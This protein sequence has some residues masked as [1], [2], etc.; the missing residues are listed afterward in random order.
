MPQSPFTRAPHHQGG[1][2]CPQS[3]AHITAPGVPCRKP[4]AGAVGRIDSEAPYCPLPHGLLR[5]RS[6]K[7]LR[8]HLVAHVGQTEVFE[9][10]YPN[11]EV[12]Y[13]EN[14]DRQCEAFLFEG[15][16]DLAMVVGDKPSAGCE[17]VQLYES[18]FYFWMPR[19]DPLA[20]V[21]ETRPLEIA[22][23][24]GR[25]IAIP[26]RRFSC[27]D[28]LKRKAAAAGVELGAV[29]EVNEVF[30]IYNYAAGRKGLAF[31]N[32]TLVSVPVM[33][34]NRY[35][36][37]HPVPGLRWKFFLEHENGHALDEAEL[38]FW[39]WCIARSTGLALNDLCAG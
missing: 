34:L 38:P 33:E 7:A 22:D 37:A 14:E 30:R 15:R 20:Q 1:A 16:Y 18:P 35:V 26:G 9:A 39:N 17:G 10:L 12:Q 5:L 2:H 24:A 11:I 6:L 25:D 3:F 27:F 21:A 19:T 29:V 13:W 23:L 8:Q 31:S 4:G 32:G 36:V 28:Y